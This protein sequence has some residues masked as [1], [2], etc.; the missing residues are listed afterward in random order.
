MAPC[1]R[2]RARAALF[3]AFSA[4]LCCL[5]LP[6]SSSPSAP[7]AAGA[8]LPVQPLAHLLAWPAPP[9]LRPPSRSPSRTPSPSP[10][11][12]LNAPLTRPRPGAPPPPLQPPLPAALQRPAYC[13]VPR[14]QQAAGCGLA[15]GFAPLLPGDVAI[16]AAGGCHWAAVRGL[17][18]VRMCTHDPL[19]DTQVSAYLHSRGSWIAPEELGAYLQVACSPARPFMLDVG[20]N[21]GSYALPAAALGCSVV[22]FEP[23]R[24]NLGRLLESLRE[25]GALGRA[26]LYQNF[27]G[28]VHSHR[29]V[30]SNSENM[31][32]TTFERDGEGEGAGARE[33]LANA[34]FVV[35]AGAGPLASLRRPARAHAAGTHSHTN[36][37]HTPCAG[38]GRLFLAA[39]AAAVAAHWAPRGARRG[40]LCQGGRRG[41]RHGDFF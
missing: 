1:S 41:L 29:L 27:V 22:A 8:P 7:S 19:A 6:A 5:L 36:P 28:A 18:G 39:L 34:S 12:P 38:A 30:R 13:K 24:D 11:P 14:C 31:G 23:S 40:G 20:A 16:S 3:A 21:I 4:L 33:A 26:A 10:T 9:P 2:Q 35:R 17:N 37:T 15:E 32:G 25:A